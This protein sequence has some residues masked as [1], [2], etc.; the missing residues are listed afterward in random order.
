MRWD[1]MRWDEMNWNEQRGADMKWIGWHDIEGVMWR[2]GDEMARQRWGW[3]ELMI[4]T[5][6]NEFELIEWDEVDWM[7]LSRED[8]MAWHY[9]RCH[10]MRWHEERRDDIEWMRWDWRNEMN[11]RRSKWGREMRMTGVYD[12]RLSEW[13]WRDWRE[14]SDMTWSDVSWHAMPWN[15]V[16]DLRW[17]ESARIWEM[18]WN[19]GDEDDKTG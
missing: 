18:R 4:W 2:L 10:E 12:L 16:R 9:M 1:E 19:W 6:V 15:E 7:N 3:I 5:W 13:N 8:E 17:R 14:W 11:W